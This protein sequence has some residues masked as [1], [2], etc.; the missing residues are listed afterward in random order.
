MRV[1]DSVFPT[2]DKKNVPYLDAIRGIAVVFI[3]VRHA[4]GLSGSP[5]YH[6]WG[7]DLSPFIVMMSSGVDLFFVLSG[8]LLSA[9]F[10]RADVDDRPGPKFGRY[11]TSRVLRIGPPYWAVLFLVV[12][13]YTPSMI[14]N[15]RVWSQHGAAML[16]AHVAIM[17]SLFPFSF[18]AYWIESPFWTLTVEMVFYLML[19]VAVRAFY[20]GRWWQGIAAA[21]AISQIW[22]W[23][24]RYHLSDCITWMQLH[25]FGLTFSESVLRFFLSHQILGYLPHF[26][27]GIGI[28]ALLLKP[29]K[30]LTGRRAGMA[31]LVM[32]AGILT[33]TMYALGSLSMKHNFS[34][35]IVYMNSE[36]TGARVYYFLESLPFAI[37]YGLIILGCSLSAPRVHHIVSRPILCRVGWLGYSIYLVHMPLLYTLSRHSFIAGAET[38]YSHFARLLVLGGFVTLAVSI[39]LFKLIEKPAMAW[40]A[41]AKRAIERDKEAVGAVS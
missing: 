8:V 35:P 30:G 29:R 22:L 34:D 12:L 11:L 18:G 32:G 19:P 17:Q 41:N 27:I 23:A 5:V 9:S 10:L 38:V 28:S 36:S 31:Y 4:W 25:S 20:K 15:D 13:L 37:A 3:F 16:I 39:G 7:V 40:A 1:V 2:P 21:I 24:V 14:P 33:V 6:L 26:A